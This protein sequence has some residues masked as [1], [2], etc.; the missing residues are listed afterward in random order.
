MARILYSEIYRSLRKR[1]VEGKHPVGS[2]LPSEQNLSKEFSCSRMTVRKAISLLANEGL[3]QSIKGKG[4]LVIETSP[5]GTSKESAFT[6]S[7]LSSFSESAHAIGAIPT[8]K[9]VYLEHVSTNKCLAQLTGFP[10]G[11]D[12]THLKLVRMLDDKPVAVDRHYF[13]TSSVPGLNEQN[14]TLSLFHYIED[15]LGLTIAVSKR[16]ITLAQPDTEDCRL[17][18]IDPSSYLAVV[19]SQTFD[20]TGTQFEYI[21]ARYIPSIF[22]FHDTATRTPLP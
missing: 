6:V 1:I 15:E 16:T 7:D 4:V 17:L 14:A 20:S 8:S 9:I 10:E 3:V 11:E 18:D 22:H 2:L 5:A 19:T 21:E 13:L 12:L